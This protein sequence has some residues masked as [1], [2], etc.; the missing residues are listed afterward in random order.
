M[1]DRAFMPILAYIFLIIGL[2]AS[3]AAAAEE[4]SAGGTEGDDPLVIHSETLELDNKNRKVVFTGDVDARRSTFS[5]NCH[6]MHLYYLGDSSGDAQ[7][8]EDLQIDRVEASGEV[9]ITRSVG[10]TARAEKAVYFQKDDKVVLTGNPIVTQGD[11]LVEGSSITFFIGKKRSIVEGSEK[12]RA[13]AVIYPEKKRSGSGAAAPKKGA[14]GIIEGGDD[15]LVVLSKKLTLDN[16]KR[17]A[18]FNGMVDAR[19]SSFRITCQNMQLYYLGDALEKTGG[20]GNV[21]VDRVE[22]S[23]N[24][25]ITRSDGGVAKSDRAVYYQK[26]DKVVLTGNPV[27]KQGDDFVEGSKITF[28][29][30]E[31]RSIV[32]GSENQ[33]VR[34]V[35]FPG[36]RKR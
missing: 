4:N 11:D 31:K 32:D 30:G 7:G 23:G 21:R 13:R 33:R 20:S 24:V 35:I 5:I 2:M 15:P 3:G 29:I 8:A 36:K 27:V 34:A 25:A 14:A 18:V 19:K 10:G 1:R 22:A 17:K 16:L 9:V 26:G 12:D 28:F 6:E